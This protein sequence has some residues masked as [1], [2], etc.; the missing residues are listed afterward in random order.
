MLYYAK[1]KN[2]KREDEEKAVQF[3][4]QRAGG[5]C[6]TADGRA[7]YW[8]RSGCP[9]RKLYLSRGDGARPIQRGVIV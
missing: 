9:E 1:V 2:D 3:P 8:P 6:E 7:V 5:G 4:F